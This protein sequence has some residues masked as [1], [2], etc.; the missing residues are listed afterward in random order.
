VDNGVAANTCLQA[1]FPGC[2]IEQFV[3]FGFFSHWQVTPHW[4][5]SFNVL[6]VFNQSAP[7]DPQAAYTTRN[8]DNAYDQEGAIGRFFQ[9]GFQVKY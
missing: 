4:L 5:L 8:Y 2:K 3:D 7:L 6:D 9:V 1:W